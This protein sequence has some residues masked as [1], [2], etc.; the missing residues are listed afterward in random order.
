[1]SSLKNVRSDDL[2]DYTCL[3]PVVIKHTTDIPNLASYPDANLE[4]ENYW[5]PNNK[6]RKINSISPIS[7]NFQAHGVCIAQLI[8]CYI[9]CT[10]Y[11][12]WLLLH[13]R[14]FWL[15]WQIRCMIYKHEFLVEMTNWLHDTKLLSHR[16]LTIC[17][18]SHHFSLLPG[19]NYILD[20]G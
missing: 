20:V 18:C 1:M 15:P 16:W 9:G 6:A 5:D 3:N 17:S 14:E 10:F 11:L 13:N 4:I 2:I 12:D 8:Q 7:S 19:C